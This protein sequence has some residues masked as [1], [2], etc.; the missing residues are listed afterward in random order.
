MPDAWPCNPCL[1]TIWPGDPQV[2]RPRVL[3]HMIH[4][5]VLYQGLVDQLQGDLHRVDM[6]STR[7]WRRLERLSSSDM[8]GEFIRD[9]IWDGS[10]EGEFERCRFTC[11][12]WRIFTN[13]VG[14]WSWPRKD[15]EAIWEGLMIQ[16]RM[17]RWIHK[18]LIL[19][20]LLFP[21]LL[22]QLP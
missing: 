10:C 4:H 14:G 1:R 9:W 22:Y 15:W 13:I 3:R 8:P 19:V 7:D 2:W 21:I 6:Y 20:C 12:Q 5:S 18:V 11:R 16:W 17:W